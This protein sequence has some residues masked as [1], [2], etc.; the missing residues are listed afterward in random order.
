MAITQPDPEKF[1][2]AEREAFIV[3]LKREGKTHEQVGEILGIS[4]QRV[5]QIWQRVLRDIPGMELADYRKEQELLYDELKA[6]AFEVLNSPRPIVTPGGKVVIDPTTGGLLI[7]DG[8][9][10]AAIDRI[11]KIEVE[12]K[13]LHGLDAPEKKQIE[14]TVTPLPPDTVSFLEQAR[15]RNEAKEQEL[16]NQPSRE[17]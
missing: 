14:A 12:R 5:G 15:A 6:R 1:D 8:Q 9:T 2:T 3:R 4:K 17:D 13:K 10:L 7:D 11:L 16:R